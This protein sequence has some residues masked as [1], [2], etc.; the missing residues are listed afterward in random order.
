MGAAYHD[1]TITVDPAA[2]AMRLGGRFSLDDLDGLLESVESVLPVRVVRGAD[3]SV[4]ISPAA[5]S[6]R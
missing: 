3:G 5:K 2:A 4:R 6:G 1:R